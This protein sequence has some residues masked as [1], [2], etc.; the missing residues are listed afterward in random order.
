MDVPGPGKSKKTTLTV[1]IPSG[2]AIGSED[3][4]RVKAESVVKTGVS[5]EGSCI[6]CAAM[7]IIP[8]IDDT[9]VVEGSPTTNYGGKAFMYTGSSTTGIYFICHNFSRFYNKSTTF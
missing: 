8:P 9:Q 3:E 5:D 1:T 6:V 2:A 7:Q 4:I